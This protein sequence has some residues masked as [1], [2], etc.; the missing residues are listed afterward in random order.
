MMRLLANPVAR[1][2]CQFMG[3]ETHAHNQ[4]YLLVKKMSMSVIILA[5][6]A[7]VCAPLPVFEKSAT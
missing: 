2:T 6:C 5:I 4:V 1:P 7:M 3:R